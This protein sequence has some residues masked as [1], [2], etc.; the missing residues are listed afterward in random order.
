MPNA[1]LTHKE[2]AKKSDIFDLLK[3]PNLN[4]IF[5]TLATEVCLSTNV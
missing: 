2:L 3:N 4:K 5:A 1:N